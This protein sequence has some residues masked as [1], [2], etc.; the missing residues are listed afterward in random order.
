MWI[1]VTGSFDSHFN[2]VGCN[3]YENLKDKGLCVQGAYDANKDFG[4]TKRC[5]IEKEM[6]K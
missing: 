4:F 6:I 2:T 3:V 1:E 5:L